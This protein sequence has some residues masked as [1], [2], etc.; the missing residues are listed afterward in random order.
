MVTKDHVLKR[1]EHHPVKKSTILKINITSSW[2]PTSTMKKA[3]TSTRVNLNQRNKKTI[4]RNK[5]TDLHEK[6]SQPKRGEFP[7]STEDFSSSARRI[8]ILNK[9]NSHPQKEE[10]H[11][12]RDYPSSTEE[13]P[14]SRTRFPS[15]TRRIPIP[16]REEFP[17]WTKRISIPQARTLIRVYQWPDSLILTQWRYQRYCFV[18]SVYTTNFYQR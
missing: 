13:Y 9:K 4:L 10:F 14:S 3:P 6:N 12:P 17:S 1:H 15:S 8:L 5:G 18:S 2:L 16:P 7:S 11:P